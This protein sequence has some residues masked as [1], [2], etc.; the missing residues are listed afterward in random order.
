MSIYTLLPPPDIAGKEEIHATWENGFS[1]NEITNLVNYA[2]TLV[3]SPATTAGMIEPDLSIRKSTVSWIPYCDQSSWIYDKLGFILRQLNG[4]FFHYDISGFSEDFQYTVYRGN[5][6]AF[7]DWHMDKGLSS[8]GLAPRKLSM[9]IQLS[10][11]SEY[12]GG[13][14]QFMTKSTVDNL[15]KTRGIVHVFPSW[16]LHRVTPVTKGTRK[17]LVVWA[18]GPKFK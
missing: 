12:E 8:N 6:N 14:L 2:D 16:V 15:S 3:A 17:S 13:E 11:P 7:Y 10:D 4:Q 5:E 9:T 1:M 18:C